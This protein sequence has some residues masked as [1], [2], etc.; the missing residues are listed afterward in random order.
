MVA[1]LVPANPFDFLLEPA[2]EQYP[3]QYGPEQ[4][5]DLH[6][7]L[8]SGSPGPLLRMFLEGFR[9]QRTGTIEL[10]LLLNRRI[11]DEVEYVTRLEA[12][13]QTSEETLEKRSGS[14][15]DSAWLLVE[16][17]RNLGIAARFVSGYLIQ[18]AEA[19]PDLNGSNTGTD[20]AALHAWA[21]AFLP[22]AGWIGL[23]PPRAFSPVKGTFRLRA[24]LAPLKR[25]QFRARLSL[26]IPLSAYEMSVC[27]LNEHR[28]AP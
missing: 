14:C 21:E 5:E 11:R 28:R 3:F 18:L 17:L 23:I 22:G 9:S 24:P 4:A 10:L 7:Y 8:L 13:I 2:A 15:R 6:P 26:Q 16:I 1:N 19:D 20:T 27:R 12:G 25:L